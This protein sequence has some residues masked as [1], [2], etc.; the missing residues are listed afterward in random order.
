MTAKEAQL[1]K[2]EIQLKVWENRIDQLQAQVVAVQAENGAG[3]QEQFNNLAQKRVELA[4][5]FQTLLHLNGNKQAALTINDDIEQTLTTIGE[6]YDRIKEMVAQV[7]SMGWVEGMAQ[8]RISDSEGWVQG[9]G[10]RGGHSEG[11]VE[12]IGFREEDS[13]GWMEGMMA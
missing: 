9:M 13:R 4:Q 8:K 12:G 10:R 1:K 2:L 6:S 3:N 7:S 5:K 11:W